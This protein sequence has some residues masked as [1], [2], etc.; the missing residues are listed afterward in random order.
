MIPASSISTLFPNTT[1]FRYCTVTIS[2]S[3]AIGAV[4]ASSHNATTS[5]TVTA[6]DAAGNT[7]V[8]NVVLTAKDITAPVLTAAAD[9]NINLD[10]ACSITIPDVRGTAT[11]NC[12]VTI[13]QSPGIGAVIASSHNATTSVT[14]TATDAAGNTDIKTVVLTAKD[15]TA[16]VLTAAADQNINLDAACSI[17]I[18]DVRG[19]ATDNCTVSISQS[20]AIGAVI[21][22]S[23]NATTSV[24]G[25]ATDAAGNKDR[26]NV[27]LTAQDITAPVLTAAADQNINLDA[28]CSI[29]IP[30][31]RGTATDNCTVSISQSPAIGAVIASSH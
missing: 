7:D 22:S 23:H 30:D 2:Q 3:P 1:V 20:P 14:V 8:K 27:V 28:A 5:V 31:V 9:Q 11:D 6:V 4:I 13:S 17:T 29:T 19:T 25:T 21:A 18:P 24:T 10:A 15:I 16:P 26:K 12:T